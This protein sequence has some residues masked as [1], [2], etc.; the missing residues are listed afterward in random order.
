MRA[1]QDL[2]SRERDLPGLALMLDP[3]RLAEVIGCGPLRIDYLRLKSATSCVASYRVGDSWLVAKAVTPNRVDELRPGPD[4]GDLPHRVLPELAF[5]IMPAA[6]DRRMRGLADAMDP[7]KSTAFLAHLR[8]IGIDADRLV[9]LKLKP[10]RRLVGRLDRRGRPA[11]FLKIHA[12]ERFADALIAATLSQ[13]GP[14]P[15]LLHADAKSGVLLTE[16]LDGEALQAGTSREDQFIL[17]GELL[18][19]VHAADLPMPLRTDRKDDLSSLEMVI[20]D[21]AHLLP[22]LKDR[23]ADL[24]ESLRV[25]LLSQPRTPGLI[26]GDFSADQVLVGPAGAHLIDWDRSAI[27]DRGSDIGCFLARLGKDVLD[28]ST[29]PEGAAQARRGFLEGYA[30]RALLPPSSAAQKLRHLAL[31]LTEDFRHQHPDWDQRIEALLALIERDLLD[32]SPPL[33]GTPDAALPA[34]ADALH[35]PTVAPLLEQS[36]FRLVGVP[37]LFRHK[38]G[39]RAMVRYDAEPKPLL[40]KMRRKGLD[41]RTIRLQRQLRAAGFDGSPPLCVEV[42]DVVMTSPELGLWAMP[43]LAGDMLDPRQHDDGAFFANGKAL[44]HLHSASVDCDRVWTMQDEADVLARALSE[45]E[46]MRPDLGRDLLEIREKARRMIEDCPLSEE[47]LL[48]RDFYPDQVLVQPKGIVLLDLDL[49]A[50]GEPAIDLG[51]FL[52]HLQELSLRIHSELDAY[53]GQGEAFLGGY[54][55]VRPLPLEPMIEHMR[56]I[57]LWRHLAICQRFTQRQ[58]YFEKLLN[59]AVEYSDSD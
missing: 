3:S 38:P 25:A 13:F 35:A 53:S 24:G 5:E 48:H 37:R 8:G 39:R 6:A 59:H 21:C 11:A 55:S 15:R 34:L 20:A 32:L 29:T 19:Q 7:Q 4:Q 43:A 57:S 23:L 49:V 58:G 2:I 47:A 45:V 22:S 16:W 36:G 44:A 9:P 33:L 17:A 42:P 41:G 30:A 50:M 18:A 54:A 31:L 12:R 46:A 26:H 51:N 40:G 28:G 52:A 14:G 10:Q 1:N 56:E 27:G